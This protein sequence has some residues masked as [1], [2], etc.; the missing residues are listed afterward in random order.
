MHPDRA[1]HLTDPELYPML[2][3]AV[4][5]GMV[6]A[7]SP[8]GPRVAHTPLVCTPERKI[9]FHLSRDNALTPHLEGTTALLLVNGPHAYVSPRWY[10]DSAQVPT[11]NYVALEMEGMVSPLASEGLADLLGIIGARAEGRLGG[12]DPWRPDRVPPER[13]TELFEGIVG[14]EMEVAE[15]RPTFKLSQNK[16]A[17]DRARVADALFEE[18][19]PELAQLMRGLD[20][21]A[22]Q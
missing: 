19:A 22:E 15:W 11:W 3:D 6:F 1:F 14:F 17:E 7:A 9:R 4:G 5:L 16:S 18:G 2:I 8:D 21:T 10:E 20:G 13:W 12:D